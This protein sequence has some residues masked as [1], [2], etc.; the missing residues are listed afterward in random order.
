VVVKNKNGKISMVSLDDPR[1]L[2]GELVFVNTGRKLSQ[3]SRD[4]ISLALKNKIWIYNDNTKKVKKISKENLEEY[5][6]KDWKQ[7][8]K[9]EYNKRKNNVII[10]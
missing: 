1:Y 9:K 2:S 10:R 6:S 4:Q 8:L 7:G 5:L 3:K